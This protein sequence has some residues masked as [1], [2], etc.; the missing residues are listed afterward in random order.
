MG[1]CFQT[2]YTLKQYLSKIIIATL[3]PKK[4][5]HCS[6]CKIGLVTIIPIY[7]KKFLNSVTSSS[8]LSFLANSQ[9]TWVFNC[10]NALDI[11]S[12]FHDGCRIPIGPLIHNIMSFRTVPRH[13]KC[14]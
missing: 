7:S 1:V 5:F 11:S 3:K 10:S 6:S 14:M 13:T 8:V 2:V 9:G 12:I 4:C